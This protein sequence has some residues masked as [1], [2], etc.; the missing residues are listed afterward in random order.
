MTG[1]P[2]VKKF[3]RVFLPLIGV[4]LGA[5]I[6][7]GPAARAQEKDNKKGGS[8]NRL[9][10]IDEKS[11]TLSVSAVV[12]KQGTFDVLKGA[13]E[14]ILVFREGKAYESLFVTDCKPGD[15]NT[16]LLALGFRKGEP[17]REDQ[18]PRGMGVRVWV[19]YTL[20]GKKTRRPIDELVLHKDREK[21]LE[22]RPWVFT[23]SVKS[24]DPEAGGES[25]QCT[26]TGSLIGLHYSDPSSLLQNARPEARQENIY[27]AHLKRLPR[28]N[29][30]VRIIFERVLPRVPP[31]TK[32]L[33]LFILG[34]VQ[35]V[36]F[37]N[38]TQRE[39][40]KLKLTGWV[41]NLAD[42]RV[43]AVIEGP[44]EDLE[45]L[46]VKVGR[47]PRAARVEKIEK[48]EEPAEGV[49]QDFKVRY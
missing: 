14:Y 1:N 2:S 49:F 25:L 40:R 45:K 17:G 44:G 18:P 46:L 11:K 3:G 47:G 22:A 5:L 24:F 29:T 38:F 33:H 26:Q 10:I 7:T 48:K 19:E 8:P 43:E 41:K 16:A 37:R 21:P 23:G 9:L 6:A 31:G 20:E 12:A 34:R 27:K 30:P 42:G 15:L 4:L 28:E 39:A 13:I 36:G 32:C 35:G